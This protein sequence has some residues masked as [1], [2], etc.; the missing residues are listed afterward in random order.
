MIGCGSTM[1]LLLHLQDCMV[2]F[3]S[4]KRVCGLDTKI[5]PPWTSC[6]PLFQ[7]G[8]FDYYYFNLRR[9]IKM[10]KVLTIIKRIMTCGTVR[11]SHF[12]MAIF[13]MITFNITKKINMHKFVTLMTRIISCG[14]VKYNLNCGATCWLNLKI[15][16]CMV[17][18]WSIMRSHCIWPHGGVWVHHAVTLYMAAWWHLRPSC[19]YILDF[20][21]NHHG[22]HASYHS[23]MAHL[24]IIAFT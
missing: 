24:I 18:F 14:T 6:I 23:G 19:G 21:K 1:R 11:S 9:K 7:H 16:G 5:P 12:S 10:C 2:G 17:G 20:V 13:I 8:H 4:I 3:Q 15:E 22:H